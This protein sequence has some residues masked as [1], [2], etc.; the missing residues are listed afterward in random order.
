MNKKDIG[1]DHCKGE[2]CGKPIPV[3]DV[4]FYAGHCQTCKHK[5]G[6]PAPIDKLVA[7]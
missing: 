1:Q 5:L 3:C 6:I 7:A 4:Y 2:G